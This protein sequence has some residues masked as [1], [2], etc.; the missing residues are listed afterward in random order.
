[1]KKSFTLIFLIILTTFP[2]MCWPGMPM[3]KLHIEGRWLIDEDG[4]KVN[5]HGFGQTYSP[6]FNEQGSKWNNYDVNACLKYNKDIMDGVLDRAGWKMTYVRMHMDPYW[7]NTPG[8]WPDGEGDISAFSFDRFKKY[9]DQVFIPMAEYAISK[10]LYVVMRPPGVCPEKIE[11]GGNYHK[12]LKQVWGHVASTKRLT[13]NPYVMFELANE[14]VQIKGTDGNYGA[15]SDACNQALTQ[16]FQEIVDLMRE[17]GCQNI[18]WVPGTAYQSQYAGFAKYPIKGENIGYAV[19]VYPGW[20]GSDA[21]EPSHELGGSYG[22]GYDSF[23]A[24]WKNQIEPCAAIAP[25]LVTEM[26]WLPSKYQ[27]SWGKSITGQMLGQGFGANF[28]LLADRTGNIGWMLF[29][30]PEL[31][32]RFDGKPGSAGNYTMYNDPDG[33]MWSAYHWFNEYAG[34][35]IPEVKSVDLFFSPRGIDAYDETVILTGSSKGAALIADRGIGVDFNVNGDIDVEISNPD[36]LNW[37]GSSFT[38]LRPGESECDVKYTIDG[39]KETKSLKFISTP[40]PLLNGY[41]NPSIWENGSF[42]E[43]TGEITTGQYGFA[44]WKYGGGLDL[45]SYKYLICEVENPG[46]GLSLRLFDTDNYWSDPAMYDFGNNSRIVIDLKN[47]K[48]NNNHVAVDPSHLYIIGFWTYGGHTFKIKNM[49]PTDNP[50]ATA[51]DAISKDKEINADGVVFNLQGIRVAS[52]ISEISTPGIYIV[53][54]KK[55]AVK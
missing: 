1:M 32:A 37:D 8:M 23:A 47:M 49:F 10:G 46:G 40:F 50:N 55:I 41:F 43:S 45:S 7:S 2:A 35:E 36:V 27:A 42:N 11:V 13:D 21:I 4:N 25:M 14:P 5:L 53:N 12:Y 18:L 26:D 29:T 6:W 15:G 3:P 17:N 31:L 33:C 19:H 48:S 28:K 52:S 9:L 22:G 30:G 44:G 54:G 20:Y 24:G 34:V 38:A 16:F 51:V 39:K